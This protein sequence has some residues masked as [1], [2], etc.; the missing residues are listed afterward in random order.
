MSE[1]YKT[2]ED[3]LHF[4]SSANEQSPIRVLKF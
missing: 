4:V 1:K 3:G 2:T